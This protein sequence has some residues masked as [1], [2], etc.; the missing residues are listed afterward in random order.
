MAGTVESVPMTPEG[1]AKLRR[2]LDQ[3][4]ARRPAILETMKTAREHGDL[5][6]NAEFHAAHE[7]LALVE[8]RIREVGGKLSRA[9]IVETSADR[10]PRG[11]VAFGATVKVRDLDS[12]DEEEYTLVGSGEDDFLKGRIATTSPVG[13]ALLTRRTGEEVEVKVPRGTMRLRIE[14]IR[15]NG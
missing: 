12:N 9:Q 2:E 15:Y 6:E 7:E 8:S 14:D 11:T 3:L 10:A 4:E 1:H 13:R 5:S